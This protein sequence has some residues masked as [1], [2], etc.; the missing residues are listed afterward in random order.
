MWVEVCGVVCG[1]GWQQE[2][3]RRLVSLLAAADAFPPFRL[4][5]RP[6]TLGSPPPTPGLRGR[7][8]SRAGG[9]EHPGSAARAGSG[10][11]ASP[12]GVGFGARPGESAGGGAGI[13]GSSGGGD[14]RPAPSDRA[15]S[16]SRLLNDRAL[17][18][19]LPSAPGPGAAAAAPADRREWVTA[20]GFGTSPPLGGGGSVASIALG[21]PA[22]PAVPRRR[23]APDA[24]R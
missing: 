11:V 22:M 8:G 18:Y 12:G 21:Y 3:K 16:P 23:A 2:A 17:G 13:P 10:G 19:Y 14:R 7:A 6:G 24:A 4:Q 5:G 15:G 1:G 20:P 9:G